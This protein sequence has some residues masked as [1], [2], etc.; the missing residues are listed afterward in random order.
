MPGHFARVARAGSV[1]AQLVPAD[2]LPARFAPAGSFSGGSAGALLP[3][4][5]ER[6][7]RAG[8]FA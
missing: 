7:G 8:A 5:D 4:H 1:L 6:A 2:V 3:V